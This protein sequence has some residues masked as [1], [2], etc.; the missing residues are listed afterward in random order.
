MSTV[1]PDTDWSKV[2]E[3]SSE[4]PR[5]ALDSRLHV[6]FYLRPILQ[7]SKSDA[8]GR[9]IYADV[10]HVRILVP[11]DKQNIIDRIASPDDKQRFAAQY[12]KF[13]AGQGQEVVGTRLEAVP[14]MTRSKVEEYKFFNVFTVEQLA[15]ASDQVGQK[16]PGFN[17][18]RE[19]AKK[20]LEATQGVSAQVIELQRQLAELQSKFAAASEPQV[21]EAKVQSQAKK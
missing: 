4:E 14:W 19:K 12:A 20:F 17:S 6:Q 5:F 18:D 11:G 8:E 2:A 7:Q 10:E 21:P 3:Q 16:F 1:L 13:K 9:P 15:E